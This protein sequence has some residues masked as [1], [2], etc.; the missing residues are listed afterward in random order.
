[1]GFGILLFV[2]QILYFS[3]PAR[4]LLPLARLPPPAHVLQPI[5]RVELFKTMTVKTMTVELF[6][7]FLGESDQVG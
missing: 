3:W 6:K 5:G 7:T 1:L 4:R 2:F